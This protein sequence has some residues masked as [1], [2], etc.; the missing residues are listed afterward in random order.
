M[1]LK[2]NASILFLL[3]YGMITIV[4]RF[5]I[6]STFNVGF[7]TSLLIGISFLGVLGLLFKMGF[8]TLK[9]E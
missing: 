6:E 4:G 8:L 9:E 5:H 1:K 2:R 3:I 7:L